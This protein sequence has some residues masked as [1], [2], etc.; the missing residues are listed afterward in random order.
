LK[1]S[2]NPLPRHQLVKPSTY[3]PVFKFMIVN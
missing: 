2:G 1:R 3:K